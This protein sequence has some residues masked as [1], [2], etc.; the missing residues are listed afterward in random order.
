MA[1]S[2]LD[3]VKYTDLSRSHHVAF[4]NLVQ[5]KL[6]EGFLENNGEGGS[7]WLS[8][9]P[10][11]EPLKSTEKTLKVPWFSQLDSATAH[12]RRMCFSSSCAMLVEYMHPGTLRGPNGDDQYLQRVLK[13][14]DTTNPIAQIQA[15]QSY[16]VSAEYVRDADFSVI[17]QQIDAGFPVPCGY[18][19]RGHISAPKGGGHWLTVVG[20]TKDSVVV[21]DPF[22]ELDLINGVFHANAAHYAH[23]SR[24]NFGK[25]WM[26]E[27]PKTGWAI[28]AKR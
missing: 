13:F 11:K 4:W 23:Y 24:K 22:G 25:R 7:L 10:P 20:Y 19:H 5:S 15:L 1:R 14:G 28:I 27:G 26:V 8:A 6:P 16:E 18:L 2:L 9:V 12:G 3:C 21:H 17:E